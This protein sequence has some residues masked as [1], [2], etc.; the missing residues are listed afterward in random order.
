MV[1]LS[2]ADRGSAGCLYSN[3]L[4][5]TFNARASLCIVTGDARVAPRSSLVMVVRSTPLISASSIWVSRLRWRSF[6]RLV[7]LRTLQIL[8]KHVHAAQ[9]AP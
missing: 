8:T 2:L 7:S 1:G 5:F 9:A 3:A 4:G 6:F